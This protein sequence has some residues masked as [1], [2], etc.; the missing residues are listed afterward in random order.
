MPSKGRA[1]NA[2]TANRLI[3][4]ECP[5]RLVVEPQ[6][7]RAYKTKYGDEHVLVLPWNN[8]GVVA[9]RNW[10]KQHSIAAGDKRHWQLDDNMGMFRRWYRKAR[11]R[12]RAGA[13]LR[14]CEEWPRRETS[15]AVPPP[16]F[17]SLAIEDEAFCL[18]GGGGGKKVVSPLSRVDRRA[19]VSS[20]WSIQ[21]LLLMCSIP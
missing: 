20:P 10:I 9:A 1:D 13:A 12:V 8:R 11:I 17:H 7:E 6:D 3:G 2:A 15:D 18:C 19:Q 14:V 4:D 21:W 16:F 5:F